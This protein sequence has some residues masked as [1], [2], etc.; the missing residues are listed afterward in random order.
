VLA[1]EM[2]DTKII[3]C[4]PADAPMLTSGEKQARNP[5]GSPA[6]PNAAFKPHPMQ[7]WSPDFIPKLTADAVDM[8]VIHRILTVA[9]PD[10]MKNSKAL[11]QRADRII[12]LKEA[13]APAV[14]P[15]PPRNQIRLAR[16]DIAVA[17]NARNWP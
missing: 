11:A 4:E 10:A 8:N 2:P 5:D 6:A 7:G 9:A 14:H 12:R 16:F 1:K 17:F 13:L 3:V 15:N